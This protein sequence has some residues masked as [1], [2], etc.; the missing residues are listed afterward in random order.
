MTT[1]R[2][3]TLQKMTLNKF[4]RNSGQTFLKFCSLDF[5]IDRHLKVGKGDKFFVKNYHFA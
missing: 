4:L 2:F 1:S 3:M 5:S